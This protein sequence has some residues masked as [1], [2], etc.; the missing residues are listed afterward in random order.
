[1]II[2]RAGEISVTINRI[3]WLMVNGLKIAVRKCA[4]WCHSIGARSCSTRN[5]RDIYRPS[6]ANIVWYNSVNHYIRL[7]YD[8]PN[9]HTNFLNMENLPVFFLCNIKYYMRYLFNQDLIDTYNYKAVFKRKLYRLQSMQARTKK[10]LFACIK[11]C[12]C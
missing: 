1:M 4:T 2:R 9:S 12:V 5:Y 11:I 10:K 3:N 6:V 7:Y 8:V